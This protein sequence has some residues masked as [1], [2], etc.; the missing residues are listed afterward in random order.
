MKRRITKTK[1]LAKLTKMVD[2]AHNTMYRCER[3]KLRRVYGMWH[4]R[5]NTLLEVRALINDYRF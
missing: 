4:E 1:L 5:Y 3:L 2:D